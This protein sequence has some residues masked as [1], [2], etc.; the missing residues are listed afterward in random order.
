[1]A[2]NSFKRVLWTC[3]CLCRRERPKRTYKRQVTR[4]ARARFK[5]MMLRELRGDDADD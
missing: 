4:Q 5:R 2:P 3:E 1:M